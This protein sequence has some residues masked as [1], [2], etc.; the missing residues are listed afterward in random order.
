M[1]EREEAI[2]TLDKV[3]IEL[4]KVDTYRI[5]IHLKNLILNVSL[6]KSILFEHKRIQSVPGGELESIKI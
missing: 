6:I 2:M 4:N 5:S 3:N 1:N